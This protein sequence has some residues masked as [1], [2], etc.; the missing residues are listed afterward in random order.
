EQMR[1]CV[2]KRHEPA[3]SPINTDILSAAPAHCLALSLARVGDVAGAEKAF[4]LAL[5]ES[6][7][8]EEVKVDFARWLVEQKR[9]VDA[10]GQLHEVVSANAQH[11]V[12]W[13]LGAEWAL[14]QPEF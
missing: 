12:A 10:F 9:P 3:L 2:A 6:G 11:T 14:A 8:V 1:H 4:Q 7:R 5:G 13:R